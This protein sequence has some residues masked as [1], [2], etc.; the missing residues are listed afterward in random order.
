MRPRSGP[1]TLGNNYI[2]IGAIYLQTLFCFRL[3]LQ[4]NNSNFYTSNSLSLKE[5]IYLYRFIYKCVWGL[6]SM[7]FV[8]FIYIKINMLLLKKKKK[9]K[10]T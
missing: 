7:H 9:K 4:E 10:D 2:K 5:K 8:Q 6:I 3:P 1:T